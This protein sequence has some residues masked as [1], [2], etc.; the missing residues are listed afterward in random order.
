MTV[1]PLAILYYITN[2][3]LFLTTPDLDWASGQALKWN[4]QASREDFIGLGKLHLANFMCHIF[5]SG[6]YLEAVAD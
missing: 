2:T 3:A 6:F 4:E 5:F 1:P